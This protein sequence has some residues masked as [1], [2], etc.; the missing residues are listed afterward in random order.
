MRHQRKIKKLSRHTS[1]R[2]ALL[3]NLAASIFLHYQIKTTL[4]KAKEVRKLVDRL[5]TY[6]KKKN[7]HGRRLIYDVIRNRKLVKKICEEVAPKLEQRNGGY[8]RVLKIAQ[9]RK[10]DGADLALVELLVEK[11]KV[12]KKK[13]KKKEKGETKAETKDEEKKKEE[14]KEKEKSKEDTKKTK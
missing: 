4:S 12:E 3:T 7:L 6:A 13:G 10:G 14:S 11:P 8:T 2:Q 1:H 9:K 5:I